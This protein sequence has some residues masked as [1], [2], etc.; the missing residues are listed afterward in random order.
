MT[1]LSN[2]LYFAGY[3]F[4]FENNL[5]PLDIEVGRHN[6]YVAKPRSHKKEVFER[7][8]L[9][10]IYEIFIFIIILWTVGYSI[11][12][13]IRDNDI[14]VF[15]RTLFQILIALQYYYAISYFS[16]NHFYE[17]IVCNKKLYGYVLNIVPIVCILSISLAIMNVCLLN[18]NYTFY[19]YN[20]MY[21]NTTTVTGKVFLSSLLFLDTLYS[22]LTF[23]VNACI[24]VINM[25]YHKNTVENYSNRLDLY[26]RQNMNTV[27]KLN[28][29]A[30]EYSQIKESFF[31]TVD[32]LTPFFSVLNYVGFIT[33]Y[34]YIEALNKH[35]MSINE[36]I[37]LILFVLV[38]VIYLISI[39]FV[40]YGVWCIRYTLN[41]NS[42]INTFFNNKTFNNSLSLNTSTFSHTSHSMYN[43]RSHIT[44]KLSSNTSDDNSNLNVKRHKEENIIDNDD[45]NISLHDINNN[46]KSYIANGQSNYESNY[47]R[48][49]KSNQTNLTNQNSEDQYVIITD[50]VPESIPIPKSPT[51]DRIPID[52]DRFDENTVNNNML[53]N[54]LIASVSNQHMLDWMSLKNV[55]NEDWYTFNIFGIEFSDTTILSRLYGIVVAILMSTQLGLLLNIW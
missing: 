7:Q 29:I 32:L 41:S 42:L 45:Q 34:F 47:H 21:T 54:I 39:H 4:D 1:L 37:N 19:I 17:N 15:G 28:I 40:N 51:S 43:D 38:E 25:L 22:Y 53:K 35:T 49:N 46:D 50:T 14:N 3:T 20:D 11:Y 27:R 18:A 8:V 55:V 36:Y 10:I 16:K 13:S 5:P 44:Q 30:I 31:K 2:I 48:N 52:D 24:F 23:T 12:M 26:I 33:M 9:N 6:T